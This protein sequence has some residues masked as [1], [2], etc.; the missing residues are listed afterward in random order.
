[1]EFPGGMRNPTGAVAKLPR[2]RGLGEHLTDEFDT[3]ASTHDEVW[4]LAEC[5]GT[6][7]YEGP[8]SDLVAA[9]E[10]VLRSTL[11]APSETPASDRTETQSP[12][13]AELIK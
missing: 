3:F 5:F 7:D 9:W 10:L 6:E 8:S 4:Q 2:L 11:R 12:L 13:K 1:M